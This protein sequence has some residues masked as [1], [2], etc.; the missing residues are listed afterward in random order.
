MIT[1]G[2]RQLNKRFNGT[3]AVQDFNA[4]FESNRIQALVGPNG[5]GKTTV[6][7]LINGFIKPSSGEIIFENR[8]I[9]A[10]PPHT[11]AHIGVGRLFQDIRIFKKLTV[12]ENLL[13]AGKDQKGENIWY[14]LWEKANVNQEEANQINTAVE[15]LK[16]VDLHDKHNVLAENLSYGEQKLLAIARLLIADHKVLL[17]DE[18]ASG[19]NQEICSTIMDLLT[20]VA[21][22]EKIVIIIEH[23]MNVIEQVAD[24]VYFMDQGKIIAQGNPETVLQ[25]NYV[26]RLYTGM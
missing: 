19:V 9:T 4:D 15:L 7:N 12:L 26:Q 23:N 22:Q 21:Q 2:I 1:L 11:I 3:W 14:A 18:P 20:K 24:H 8:N 25:D 17:L 16:K 6:F 13:V 5:A 10:L